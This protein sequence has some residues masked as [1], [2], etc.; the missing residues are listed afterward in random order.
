MNERSW[1]FYL[2]SKTSWQIVFM[3]DDDVFRLLKIRVSQG[4]KDRVHHHHQW[5]SFGISYNK[6]GELFCA[7]RSSRASQI[8]IHPLMLVILPL[9]TSCQIWLSPLVHDGQPTYF[10]NLKKFNC[11][12]WAGETEKSVCSNRPESSECHSHNSHNNNG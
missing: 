1:K 8:V 2:L 12:F 7:L 3:G 6:I 11:V 5:R 9:L 4:T 10:T